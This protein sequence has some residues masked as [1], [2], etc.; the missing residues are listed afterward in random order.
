ML[1]S[2]IFKPFWYSQ[3]LRL[4]DLQLGA[5]PRD[6]ARK[7]MMAQLTSYSFL[8]TRQLKSSEEWS[9]LKVIWEEWRK[10]I[11]YRQLS[12][13]G[14]FSEGMVV[15]QWRNGFYRQTS[16]LPKLVLFAYALSVN[17]NRKT[18]RIQC[19]SV[20]MAHIYNISTWEVET[21]GLLKDQDQHGFHSEF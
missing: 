8:K 4:S 19:L 20:L 17:I 10:T 1:N 15:G 9:F 7:D 16:L 14:N 21:R 18:L 3:V 13:W 6:T 5:K 11:L 12:T 2:I